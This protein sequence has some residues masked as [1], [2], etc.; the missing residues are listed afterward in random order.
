MQV[1]QR[2]TE[3]LG[4]CEN[5]Y[6][7]YFCWVNF[8]RCDLNTNES[9]PMCRS[10]CENMFESCGYPEEMWRCGNAEYFNAQVEKDNPEGSPELSTGNVARGMEAIQKS[11]GEYLNGYQ[12]AKG[13]GI[14]PT[15]QALE[16]QYGGGTVDARNTFHR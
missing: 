6:I 2:F 3:P 4:R 10:A 12:K 1:A 13:Y 11:V 5:A 9:L 14:H 16:E 7:S 8:P 15:Y